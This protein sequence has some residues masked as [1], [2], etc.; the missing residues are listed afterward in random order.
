MHNLHQRSKYYDAISPFF[1]NFFAHFTCILIYILLVAFF[2]CCMILYRVSW[3]INLIYFLLITAFSIMT[4]AFVLYT[5]FRFGYDAE[6]NGYLFA[7]VGITKATHRHG[8]A[9]GQK[10]LRLD[11][12]QRSRIAKACNVGQQRQQLRSNLILSDNNKYYFKHSSQ[13]L[14]KLTAVN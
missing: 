13:L 7:F 6:Q 2:S 14:K 8:C 10:R 9:S 1:I 3:S 5:S 4:Y 11:D 12:Q